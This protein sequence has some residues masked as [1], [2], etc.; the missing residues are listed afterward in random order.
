M[1]GSDLASISSIYY[2]LIDVD[3]A[4]ISNFDLNSFLAEHCRVFIQKYSY[5]LSMFSEFIP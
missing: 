1:D 5:D 4:V 3:F 2:F